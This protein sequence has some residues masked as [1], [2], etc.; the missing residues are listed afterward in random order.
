M[1][2]GYDKAPCKD[3][4]G[5]GCAEEETNHVHCGKLNKRNFCPTSVYIIPGKKS[6]YVHGWIPTIAMKLHI[7]RIIYIHKSYTYK[8]HFIC[9]SH[10]YIYI[11]IYIYYVYI[12]IYPRV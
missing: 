2:P 7:Y 4:T 8:S 3:S 1:R 5:K 10:I 6:I 9:S 11:F 12:Y